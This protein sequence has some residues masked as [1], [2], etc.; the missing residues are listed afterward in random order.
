M[1]KRKTTPARKIGTR[2]CRDAA[3][4][5]ILEP[6]R[7]STRRIKTNIGDQTHASTTLHM[8]ADSAPPPPLTTPFSPPPSLHCHP[9][10][11]FALRKTSMAQSACGVHGVVLE[12]L[13]GILLGPCN[14]RTSA[15]ACD[16]L[17]L[18][19][20]NLTCCVLYIP[21]TVCHPYKLNS[22]T[23]YSLK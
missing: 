8:F 13:R 16:T 17:V 2:M 11:N 21:T 4:T 5:N 12:T 22:I 6:K 19:F 1:P 15:H 7:N 9:S 23:Y 14:I 3:V 18:N 10:S 20:S